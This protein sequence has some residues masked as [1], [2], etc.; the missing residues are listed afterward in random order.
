MKK[1][2]L[3][4]LCSLVLVGCATFHNSD[5]GALQ[6]VWKGRVIQGNP[7][8]QC[9]FLIAGNYYEFRDEVD[10]NIWYNGTFKLREDTVPRQYLATIHECPFPQYVGKTGMAIY[11]IENGTLTITGNEPGITNVPAAF[12]APGAVRMEVKRK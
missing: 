2:L 5:L 4:G 6:G 9:S 10:T 3:A 11:R 7:E 8:H 12:D 1:L